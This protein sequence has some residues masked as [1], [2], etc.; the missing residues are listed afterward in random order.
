MAG[1]ENPAA[2]AFPSRV[3]GLIPME[4]AEAKSVPTW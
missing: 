1:V 2:A 4:E 3:D